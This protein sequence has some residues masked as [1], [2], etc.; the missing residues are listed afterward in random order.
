MGF[1]DGVIR[2]H[3]PVT[4]NPE[5]EFYLN[6]ERIEMKTGELWYLDFSQKHRVENRGTADR[7]HLVVD[8]KV[9]DWLRELIQPTV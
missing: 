6:D 9:N 3:I 4:T 2:L 5:V 1:E 7:I 8:C